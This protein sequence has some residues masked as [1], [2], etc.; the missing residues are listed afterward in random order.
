MQTPSMI[1]L[2]Q[3]SRRLSADLETPIILFRTTDG[4]LTP[5]QPLL[6]VR[7]KFPDFC[8]KARKWTADGGATASSPAII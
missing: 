6:R 8:W 2:Q 3:R 5:A 4:F 7:T 1:T